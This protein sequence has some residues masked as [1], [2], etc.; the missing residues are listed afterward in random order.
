MSKKN[1]SK[2]KAAAKASKPT[3]N[4]DRVPLGEAMRPKGNGKAKG[5]RA[6]KTGGASAEP[7]KRPNKKL[8]CLDAAAQVLKSEGKPM[9]C[10]AMID[11]MHAG[12]LWSSDAPTPHATLY[13]A[14]I[15]EIARKG[16]AARFKKTDRG[17]FTAA[18]SS[19]A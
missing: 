16:S 3:S 15:R 19:K 18:N 11:A 13:S 14:I 2:S 7:T 1:K 5:G 10:K 12:K 8:S 4:P 17:L 9:S 6:A